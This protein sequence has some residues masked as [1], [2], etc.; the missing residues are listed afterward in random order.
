MVLTAMMFESALLRIYRGHVRICRVQPRI[1]HGSVP[2]RRSTAGRK[3]TKSIG[4]LFHPYRK[5]SS[6]PVAAQQQ[7]N[8]NS[9]G[10][11]TLPISAVGTS[12]TGALFGCLRMR[13]IHQN[14]V[15]GC[16]HNLSAEHSSVGVGHDEAK[17]GGV[18]PLRCQLVPTHIQIC[19][20]CV[21]VREAGA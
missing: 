2:Y 4:Q 5:V 10:T 14:F 11:P 1:H 3:F 18:F 7:P 21:I 15:T 17:Q 8:N 12:M 13:T 20:V 9:I 6:S 16:A 19:T